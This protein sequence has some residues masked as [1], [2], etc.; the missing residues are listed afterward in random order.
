MNNPLDTGY[1][2]PQSE[3]NGVEINVFELRN[4]TIIATREAMNDS[5]YITFLQDPI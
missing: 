2:M 4:S 3:M 5:F 1:T